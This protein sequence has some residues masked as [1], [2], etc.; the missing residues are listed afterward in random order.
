MQLETYLDRI[1]YTGSRSATLET[2]SAVQAAHLDAIC[3][4][5]LD[6]HLGRSLALGANAAYQ[7]IVDR[8]SV[9]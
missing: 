2:L 4:E 7:K 8:K 9:V 6:I 3:Y 5:N 1:A